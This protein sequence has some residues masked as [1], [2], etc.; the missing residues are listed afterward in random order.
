MPDGLFRYGNHR[1]LVVH[2]CHL[3]TMV[4]GGSGYADGSVSLHLAG[5]TA[6]AAFMT[7]RPGLVHQHQQGIAITIITQLDQLL[8]MA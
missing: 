2:L 1:R 6:P 8:N 7:G 4:A 5:K 3:L